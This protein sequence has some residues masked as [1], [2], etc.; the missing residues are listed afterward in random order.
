V[1]KPRQLKLLGDQLVAVNE[2]QTAGVEHHRPSPRGAKHMVLTDIHYMHRQI[3]EI[4]DHSAAD[5]AVRPWTH[6]HPHI[7][8]HGAVAGIASGR[9]SA[10]HPSLHPSSR[11]GV[12]VKVVAR[13]EHDQ[14]TQ[15]GLMVHDHH[16]A[17]PDRHNHR[18][19]LRGVELRAG[20]VACGSTRAP[21]LANAV[22]APMATTRSSW[23]FVVGPSRAADEHL[24]TF[25]DVR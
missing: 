25:A 9:A 10:C 11:Y 3:A 23:R 7:H 13:F 4:L 15:S 21:N 22:S 20:P 24:D 12:R 2:N 17:D 18:R 16:P 19:G 1:D 8:S 14:L 6:T 5:L